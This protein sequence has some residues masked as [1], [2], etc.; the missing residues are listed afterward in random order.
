MLIALVSPSVCTFQRKNNQRDASANFLARPQAFCNIKEIQGTRPK[1]SQPTGSKLTNRRFWTFLSKSV[2]RCWR[3]EIV[4]CFVGWL[5][6]WGF[7]S[8]ISMALFMQGYV[9][10][11]Y[12]KVESSMIWINLWGDKSSG[13]VF[14]LK[15]SL[16]FHTADTLDHEGNHEHVSGGL[17]LK[18]ACVFFVL[19]L[20]MHTISVRIYQELVGRHMLGEADRQQLGHRG[21]VRVMRRLVPRVGN[22]RYRTCNA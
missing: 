21:Q 16:H 14:S 19:R 20:R 4:K 15:M 22:K 18:V 5:A 10:H 6:A 3:S 17:I 7:T 11:I 8:L 12:C 9:Y 1:I 13:R 2:G